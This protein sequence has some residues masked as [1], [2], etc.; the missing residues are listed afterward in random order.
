MAPAARWP[1]P[2]LCSC[3]RRQPDRC[4]SSR[5][6][7]RPR[8][9]SRRAEAWGRPG[10]MGQADVRL[11]VGPPG[12]PRLNQVTVT[13]NDY[14]KSVH[15]T[16]RSAS[17][18]SSTALKTPTPASKPAGARRCPSR[19]IRKKRSPRP[20]PSISNAPTSTPG[21]QAGPPGHAF[22]HGPRNQ[23]WMWRE[24]RLRDPSGNTV[25][26]YKAGEARRFPPWRMEDRTNNP[27]K[28]Q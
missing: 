18:R 24:A 25:F 13:V 22:E 12:M 4:R 15:S 28:F 19:P 11:D 26:L 3:A 20:R 6:R 14:A 8:R 5:P 27:Q 1:A 2:S 23:P 9:T 16:A 7:I 10:P 17:G 21:G